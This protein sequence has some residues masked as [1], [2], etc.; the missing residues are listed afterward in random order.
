MVTKH[1]A[2]KQL[3]LSKKKGKKKSDENDNFMFIFRVKR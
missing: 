1:L 3:F 2:V